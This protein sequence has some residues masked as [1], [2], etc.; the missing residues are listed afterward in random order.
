MKQYYYAENDHQLGPFTIEELKS[1]KIKKSTLVWTDGMD[2]WATAVTVEELKDII[3]SEPPPLRKTVIAP[4]KETIQIKQPIVKAPITSTKYDLTFEKDSTPSVIGVI[5]LI[6][7]LI[8]Y[9]VTDNGKIHVTEEYSQTFVLAVL[10]S[11][12][13]RI[14]I[15]IW[16][17]NI[18]KQLNRNAIG[19]TILGFMFPSISLVIIGQ[20]K[21]LKLN[22]VIDGRL[23]I[24]EQILILSEKA[25]S[26]FSK[27]RYNECIKVINKIIELDDKNYEA[28]KLRGI[29]YFEKGEYDKA[30]N[31]FEILEKNNKFITE[32]GK[33]IDDIKFKKQKGIQSKTEEKNSE[34][35]Y[36]KVTDYNFDSLKWINLSGSEKID[37]FMLNKKKNTNDII[38]KHKI[39]DIIQI[40][41]MNDLDELYRSNETDKYWIILE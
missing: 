30:K 27:E 41:T 1:K 32:V 35:I 28:L 3:I 38:V 37:V 24:D 18:A 17:N 4:V 16:I 7:Y 9:L 14:G 8:I 12:L 15:V 33:Y 40:K 10:I 29:S 13:L 6:I 11:F 21:K 34:N 5:L 23:P 31:D 19:W 36:K 22:I 2:D 26:F 39:Y 20:L 25:K